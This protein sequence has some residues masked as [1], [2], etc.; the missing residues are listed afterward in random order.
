MIISE[1]VKEGLIQ[2][3]SRGS[4]LVRISSD[5]AA[6]SKENVLVIRAR[7]S[8]GAPVKEGDRVMVV[9]RMRG[10]ISGWF[11]LA[12]LPFLAILCA[13]LAGFAVGLSEGAIAAV[14]VGVMF[15]YYA[16]LYFCLQK[17]VRQLEWVVGE[18][19]ELCGVN[20]PPRA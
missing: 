19:D 1:V 8:D 14:A 7:I 12:G 2:S 18:P 17:L 11:L 4:A 9:G 13:L 20:T 6:D 3:L 5:E 10:W 15:L 16:F